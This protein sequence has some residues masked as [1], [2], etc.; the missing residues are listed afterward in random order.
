MKK[1]RLTRQPSLL[2]RSGRISQF[3]FRTFGN[4]LLNIHRE[5][6]TFDLPQ[7]RVGVAKTHRHIDFRRQIVVLVSRKSAKV[8]LRQ[9]V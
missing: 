8:E 3:E 9:P 6:Q 7:A 2:E 4:G 1:N 5:K